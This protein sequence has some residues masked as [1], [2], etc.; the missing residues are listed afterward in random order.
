MVTTKKSDAHTADTQVHT[1]TEQTL[2]NHIMTWHLSHRN[3]PLQ[4]EEKAV[5]KKVEAIEV[6]TAGNIHDIQYTYSLTPHIPPVDL[7]CTS[8]LKP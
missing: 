1:Q 5:M 3:P 8:L 7:P 4:K 6:E 2:Y